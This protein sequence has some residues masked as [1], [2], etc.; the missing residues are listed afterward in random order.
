MK[1]EELD[2]FRKDLRQ[3]L[4]KYHTLKDDLAVVKKVLEVNASERPPFSFRLNDVGVSV[5]LI[6]IKNMA[7]R[8]MK[9]D[10]VNSGLRLLYA[11]LEK[12]QKVV[13]IE[14]YH[15]NEKAKENLQRVRNNFD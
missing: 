5:C 15:K 3:L 2:E 14:L 1:F 12:E 10:G 7:C 4:K 13:F 9:G 11:W 8:S 6:K